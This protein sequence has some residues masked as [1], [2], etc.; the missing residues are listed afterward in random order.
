MS[1]VLLF[2]RLLIN[3]DNSIEMEDGGW[4]GEDNTSNMVNEPYKKI[5]DVPRA[6]KGE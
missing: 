4:K 6:L 1:P 5:W 2:S 3:L